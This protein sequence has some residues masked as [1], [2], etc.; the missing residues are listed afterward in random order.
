MNREYTL[1]HLNEALEE[2][3][4]TI[5]A[6]EAGREYAVEAFEVAM[7]HLY[8]HVNTAWNARVQ[9][10]SRIAALSDEDFIRWRQFPR[11]LHLD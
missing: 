7:Q 3:H 2:L 9:P 1:W 11:D 4:R 10:E 5:A 8:H 6:I